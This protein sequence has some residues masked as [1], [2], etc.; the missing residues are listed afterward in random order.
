MIVEKNLTRRKLLKSIAVALPAGSVV[1]NQAAVAEDLPR[2]DPNDPAA[3]ALLYVENIADLDR[4]NPQAARFEE[5]QNCANC[6]QI[7]DDSGDWRP[8]AIF[9]GK[10][11][12]AAGW[13]SVWALKPGA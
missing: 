11:V 9:P 8:C 1:L 6:I 12:A 2:L 13:C 3:K 5:S 10:V 7:Q 4:S